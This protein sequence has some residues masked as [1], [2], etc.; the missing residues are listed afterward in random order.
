[1]AQ[2]RLASAL[3]SSGFG[4][5]KVPGHSGGLNVVSAVTAPCLHYLGS[6]V[7]A[8]KTNEI[9][10][11]RVLCQ[12]LDLAGRLVSIQALHTQT[13]TARRI[14]LAH[15]GDYVMT[16]KANQPALQAAEQTHM[17]G[18]GRPPPFAPLKDPAA[19]RWTDLK[20]VTR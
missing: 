2:R 11:M 7:V 8:D 18:S 3:R 17:P 6:A 1:V 4:G 15:G 14:V 12:R 5:G 16:V 20:K 10:A 9:P 13:E 19:V